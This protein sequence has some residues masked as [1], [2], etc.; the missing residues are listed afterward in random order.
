VDSGI[1]VA[2]TLD[3]GQ[4]AF[5]AWTIS[6]HGRMCWLDSVWQSAVSSRRFIAG[7]NGGCAKP[8]LYLSVYRFAPTPPQPATYCRANQRPATRLSTSSLIEHGDDIY[9]SASVHY[10]FINMVRYN[11]VL[12]CCIFWAL[13]SAAARG[14]PPLPLKNGGW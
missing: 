10:H 12:F 7:R 6:R 9:A 4:T 14:Q 11:V 2:L 1:Q 8:L 5:A 3:R 13:V